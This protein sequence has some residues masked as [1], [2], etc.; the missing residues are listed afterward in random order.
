M[1][2]RKHSKKRMYFQILVAF[3]S[4]IVVLVS[5]NLWIVLR[6]SYGIFLPLVGQGVNKQFLDNSKL[7]YIDFYEENGALCSASEEAYIEANIQ[8]YIE[9]LM[10]EIGTVEKDT[11]VRAF[12]KTDQ[13]DDYYPSCVA[14]QT[15]AA[16]HA[17]AVLRIGQNVTSLRIAVGIDCGTYIKRELRI[18]V[19][20][21]HIDQNLLESCEWGNIF[22]ISAFLGALMVHIN[23]SF[24]DSIKKVNLVE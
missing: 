22:L 16:G 23:F 10:L 8:G 19:N 9:N 24:L 15:I 18:A 4:F 7:S 20:C 3:F 17:T 13:M 5:F 11:I 14:I 12:Y 6:S 1:K 2:E 21:G